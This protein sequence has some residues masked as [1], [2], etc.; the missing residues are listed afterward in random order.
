MRFT[1]QLWVEDA[2]R[3]IQNN[4]T[5]RLESQFIER[6]LEFAKSDDPTNPFSEGFDQGIIFLIYTSLPR[7]ESGFT[8][9]AESFWEQFELEELDFMKEFKTHQKN[10]K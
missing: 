7:F 10:G 6:L 8:T 1:P 3:F 4:L 9:S 2:S 5:L